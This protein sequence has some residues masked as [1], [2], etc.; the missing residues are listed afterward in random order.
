M[1]DRLL[2]SLIGSVICTQD[3]VDVS[4]KVAFN[5]GWVKETEEL[6]DDLAAD[7]QLNS[8]RGEPSCCFFRIPQTSHCSPA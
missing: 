8:T 2:S 6:W 4:W 5:L 3:K 7:G 1:S